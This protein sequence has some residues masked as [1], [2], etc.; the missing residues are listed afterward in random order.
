V[1]TS[2]LPAAAGGEWE[3]ADKGIYYVDEARRSPDNATRLVLFRLADR[4]WIDIGKLPMLV[5]IDS[6]RL[7]GTRDGRWIA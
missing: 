5:P 2:V 6:Q 1:K 7:T 3:A 4:K